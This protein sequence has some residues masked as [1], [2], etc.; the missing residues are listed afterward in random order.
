MKYELTEQTKEM[1]DG[2]QPD[3]KITILYRIRALVDL[4]HHNVKAGDFG[5][6]IQSTDNLS[7]NGWVADEATVW[8]KALICGNARV[9]GTSE[10]FGWAIIKD[11]AIVSGNSEV[12]D[13]VVV[14]SN[15]KITGSS[16]AYGRLQ[17]IKPDKVYDSC[18]CSP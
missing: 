12:A 4:P 5:G 13:H 1:K 2:N 9:S 7:E 18:W 14:G 17:L 3:S 16:E 8:H 15:V 6:Y 11:N 10:V